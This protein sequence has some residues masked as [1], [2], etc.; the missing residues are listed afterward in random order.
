MDLKCKR[1]SLVSFKMKERLAVVT[2]RRITQLCSRVVSLLETIQA[3]LKLSNGIIACL[4]SAAEY[5]RHYLQGSKFILVTVN[6]VELITFEFF[7]WNLKE[8]FKGRKC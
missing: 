4:S 5:F 3:L 7:I 2:S 6:F 1:N 8:F